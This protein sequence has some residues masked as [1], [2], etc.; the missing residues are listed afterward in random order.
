M[1]S[2]RNVR[3]GDAYTVYLFQGWAARAVDTAPAFVQNIMGLLV[4]VEKHM[5]P[6]VI[7]AA[8]SPE[9]SGDA[10]DE[11][12]YRLRQQQLTAKYGMFALKTHDKPALLQEATRLCA[13]GLQS[14]YCKVMKF[15]PDEN[16]FVLAA[17]VGWK[18]GYV[19][20]AR[21]AADMDSPDGHAF[22]AGEGTILNQIGAETRLRT[23]SILAEHGIKRAINVVIHRNGER[24]GLLEVDSPDEGHFNEDDLAFMQGFANLIGVAIERQ[25]VEEALRNSE[26]QLK[27]AVAHQ[28]V[29]AQEI[30]HGVKNSLT[31][32]VS[33][34]RMQGRSSSSAV[35]REALEDAQSRI[36]TIARVHD[37]LWQSESVHSINLKDFLEQLCD[38]FRI[39][40]PEHQLTC[41]VA[42]VVVATDQAI[43][44]GMLANELVTNAFKYAYPN[45]AGVVQLSVRPIAEGE[46]RFEVSDRGT[47]MPSNLEADKPKSLGMK[48]IGSLCHQLGGR[49]E[50]QNAHPGTC[51]SIEFTRQAPRATGATLA[52]L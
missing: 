18:P 37:R 16:E 50:W 26:A 17:G 28:V 40:A 45:A 27:R 9:R 52:G 38:Q 31:M 6:V 49:T 35:V 23:S 46:I 39:A 1:F 36:H 12:S 4:R 13:L 25:A 29:L 43:P 19:G 24:F 32:V 33:L 14:E 34:L 20:H 22:Q 48:L 41:D 2:S 15:L 30:N 3:P 47:G 11:V 5:C 21:S 44:L 7:A 8:S 51:F 10:A 42:P